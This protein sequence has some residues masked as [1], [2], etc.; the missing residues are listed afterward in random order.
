M[1]SNGTRFLLL[2]GASDFRNASRQCSWDVEQRAFTL[3][4]QD[5]PRLPQM[6]PARARALLAAATPWILDDHGQL[7]RL[8]DDG[9]RFECALRWPAEAA[10]DWQPVLA[11]LDDAETGAPNLEAL[12]LDPVDAPAG[13]FT[14]LAFG[15]S[16]L[17]ALPW[18]DGGVGNGLTT[19]HLRRRWQT[20]CTLP[21]A[22]RRAWVEAASGGTTGADRIW[23]L[24]ETRLG[25]AVGAP[26]PQPY[27][28]RPE[29]F[30]PLQANPDPLRLLWDIALP[31]HGG[32]LGLAADDERLYV[33]S[34]ATDS[35]ADAPHMQVFSRPLAAGPTEGFRVHRLPD[36]LP[37]GLPLATDLAALGDGRFLLLLPFEEGA[38]R[39]KRRDCPLLSIPEDEDETTAELVAE[40]WPRRSE[41]ALPAAV[42]FVRH[43]D[44]APRT[45]T[46]DGPIR[47]YRLAQAHF[48][49]RGTVTL[50]E[51]LDSTMP[52]TLWDRLCLDA[53]IPPG[54]RIE[55]AVQAGDD[56][57]ELPD[58]WI[59]QPQP[60]LTPRPS[61]L[62]FAPG[63][64]PQGEEHDDHAGLYE[65]LIQRG[66]GAVREVRGRYLRLR[67]TMHGDGRH[68]PAIFAL[69]VYYPRFS[70]QTHYL[71][72][73]FQQQ[74]RPLPL[75]D[76][77]TIPANGADF[78]ERLLASLEG[79]LTP[80][81]DRIAASE[82]LLQPAA[83]PAARLPWLAGLLGTTLPRHWPE[84][85]R[86]RWLAAQGAMQQAHGSYR[87][88][89]LALDILT[90]GAVARGAVIPVEHFR[91]R[92]TMAT[93]LGIDMDD[94]DHPLTLGTGLS[95][96][97]IV[98]DS[99][100]LSD[101]QAREFLALFAP[102][103]A[104]RT[105]ETAVV[106]RFFDEAARRM[107]VILHG[108]A[109][110]LAAVVRDALPSLVPATVQWA[111]RTSEHPFVLG[112]SPLLGI[113]T[114]LETQ[115]PPRP[116]VLDRTRLGRGDL[117]HNP[118]ALDPEHA[119]P[120][121]TAV[122]DGQ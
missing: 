43:R 73:H 19:V 20:R 53:C 52:D 30:D 71:P 6:P 101:D 24:G 16:G 54:C 42:R 39:G 27:V 117:L 114:W 91:L 11:A 33:L 89:L 82:I 94:R 1:N 79:V 13:R 21:F 25:L 57:N 26:L 31:P 28:G 70:W 106:D 66:N 88:L 56:R 75:E 50:S 45:L 81:E 3:T 41:A 10:S 87:G 9:R 38:E 86:R 64:A 61:E 103:V 93:I 102:E 83:T 23:L 119:V 58:E 92:R 47:L 15:G 108:P 109:K 120:I 68:S 55:F 100:I 12:V 72:D 76:A 35:T 14:D 112:L 84:A 115:P 32:L 36:A 5:A 2:D 85:R 44:G 49:A 96:N 8:S 37:D 59:A 17:V 99:L 107:T 67:I 4:R 46:A 116:V 80:L 77:D 34:E 90:D 113:D 7:G 22:P 60:V 121:D 97:S 110:R 105:G 98:G 74:E 122:S 78:R 40:R 95:G 65:L 29:R 18:S 62:P 48:A 63:R 111:I 118:V 104:E 51:I 69:R